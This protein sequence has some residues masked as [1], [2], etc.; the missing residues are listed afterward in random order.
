M[1]DAGDVGLVGENGPELIS[2]PDS[3]PIEVTPISGSLPVGGDVAQE[4]YNPSLAYG[5]G[6]QGAGQPPPQQP[7]AVPPPAP[8]GSSS[9]STAYNTLSTPGM[10]SFHQLPAEHQPS[11]MYG[12]PPSNQARAANEPGPPT[13]APNT[14]TGVN[15]NQVQ[16][17]TIPNSADKAKRQAI[18]N[19]LKQAGQ[20]IKS[21]Q[22]AKN[23]WQPIQSAIPQP[24]AA[25][26][27]IQMKPPPLTGNQNQN[28]SLAQ[29]RAE[30]EAYYQ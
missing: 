9:G 8:S 30:L 2:A 4:A 5:Q 12:A 14:A 29:Q 10:D 19:V 20:Q 7:Y 28:Q 25:P 24:P 23:P 17:N 3:S 27:Q 22:G 16:Q 13:P 15:T 21:P 11:D 6:A 26:G 18:A 1:L